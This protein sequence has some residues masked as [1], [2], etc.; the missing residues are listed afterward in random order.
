MDVN[1]AQPLVEI[2]DGEFSVEGISVDLSVNSFTGI[3]GN[4]TLEKLG[5]GTSPKV[6]QPFSEDLLA[7]FR[8]LQNQ[9]LASKPPEVTI[10]ANAGD[11]S[12]SFRFE[13][14]IVSPTGEIGTGH[15]AG[16]IRAIHKDALIDRL[17]FSIYAEKLSSLRDDE[18]NNSALGVIKFKNPKDG[19]V[20]ALLKNVSEVLVGNFKVARDSKT[21]D[22]EK[23][24]ITYQH[25]TVN[26]ESGALQQWYDILDNSDVF[27]ESWSDLLSYEADN[28]QHKMSARHL[29]DTTLG[30]FVNSSGSFWSTLRKIMSYFRMVYVPAIEGPGR[31]LRADTVV[32]Q[33][34]GSVELSG[35]MISLRDG[36][37][38]L[39]AVG[40]VMIMSDLVNSSRAE[41]SGSR[42]YVAVY[43]P[44]GIE[45]GRLVKIPPP[46]WLMKPGADGKLVVSAASSVNLSLSSYRK[47]MESDQEDTEEKVDK[48]REV[49]TEY[50]EVVFKER[51]L[52]SSTATVSLPLTFKWNGLIGSRVYIRIYSKA[53]SNQY[54]VGYLKAIRHELSVRNGKKMDS[55]TTLM[56]THV[57]YEI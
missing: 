15:R 50:A 40:A 29:V 2:N 54:F 14:F 30:L 56:F 22:N 24:I 51:Q 55:A 43:P 1:I 12:E 49:L 47:K 4:S 34:T 38:Q 42:N 6:V 16:A 9:R 48:I 31:L 45:G 57:R 18:S 52:M 53:A 44:G 28:S 21:K 19:D 33:P 13:G 10:R 35:R 26:Q 23:D 37:S 8:S 32:A 5:N 27:Y 36:D 41:T 20:I 7:T 17:N 11:G 46:P 3:A 25:E 39:M